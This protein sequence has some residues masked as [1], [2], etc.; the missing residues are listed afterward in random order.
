VNITNVGQ[1]LDQLAEGDEAVLEIDSIGV[2]SLADLKKSLRRLGY[3][4]PE[5]QEV[6]A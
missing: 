4:L 3:V 5:D 2:K 1:F 6:A